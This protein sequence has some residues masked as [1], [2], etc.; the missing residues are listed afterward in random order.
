[1]MN[2]AGYDFLEDELLQES[3]L[4][5]DDELEYTFQYSLLSR[6]DQQSIAEHKKR[7]NHR[8]RVNHKLKAKH[9][10]NEY[11]GKK[12]NTQTPIE[13]LVFEEDKY[14]SDHFGLFDAI[15]G[16]LSLVVLFI[17]FW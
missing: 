16:I 4:Q 11:H 9:Q 5:E 7:A 12:S 17:L 8:Q 14:P 15:L 1:M 6:A 13:H 2:I 10:T 3:V